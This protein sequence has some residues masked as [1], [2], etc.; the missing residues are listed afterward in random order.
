LLRGCDRAF[1]PH[2]TSSPWTPRQ[3]PCIFFSSLMGRPGLNN[4]RPRPAHPQVSSHFTTQFSTP[5]NSRV[6]IGCLFFP[7]CGVAA[8]HEGVVELAS[9]LPFLPGPMRVG[10]TAT[11]QGCFPPTIRASQLSS[12]AFVTARVP[13]APWFSALARLS[14][15]AT[16][17]KMTLPRSL[18]PRPS[19]VFHLN[20]FVMG[21]VSFMFSSRVSLLRFGPVDPQSSDIP[22]PLVSLRCCPRTGKVCRGGP[23]WLSRRCCFSPSS[24]RCCSRL[25]K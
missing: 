8:P 5:F 16:R 12:S 18:P 9:F 10:G 7:L 11:M 22:F 4:L 14:L 6:V 20:S 1:Y 13:P 15:P 23:V 2:P 24:T 17:Y 3:I 19:A 21:L 25:Q